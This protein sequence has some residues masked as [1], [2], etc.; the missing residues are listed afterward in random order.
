MVD[1]DEDPELKL[2]EAGFAEMLKSGVGEDETRNSVIAFAL[3]S[4]A[5]RV[6]RFQLASTV[7]VNE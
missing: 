2:S 6:A 4:P 5:L 7:L 3:P 1:A